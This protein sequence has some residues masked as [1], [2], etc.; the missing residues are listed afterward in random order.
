MHWTRTQRL[1]TKIVLCLWLLL[2]AM[3]RTPADEVGAVPCCPPDYICP[4]LPSC[5]A[6]GCLMVDG[7]P[8]AGTRVVLQQSDAHQQST[9][10]DP[11]GCYSFDLA[12]RGKR[13]RVIIQGSS[14]P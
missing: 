7:V 1:R 12:R 2:L 3:T 4:G 6:S 13:F 9:V 11:A 8:L 14:Q 5:V 10:T